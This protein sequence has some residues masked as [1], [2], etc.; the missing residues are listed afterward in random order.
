M[1]QERENIKTSLRKV[2]ESLQNKGW[3]VMRENTV[4]NFTLSV[5]STICL[6]TLYAYITLIKTVKLKYR[7]K[8]LKE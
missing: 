4:V 1:V 7:I 3:G 8:Y 6:L 2:E 5:L